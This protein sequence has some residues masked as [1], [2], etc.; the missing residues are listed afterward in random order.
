[1][2]LRI[3]KFKEAKEHKDDI[4]RGSMACPYLRKI[5]LGR[6]CIATTP[7]ERLNKNK[8]QQLCATE[9]DF[10]SCPKYIAKFR[11]ESTPFKL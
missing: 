5:F 2:T 3:S 4:V 11:E 7:Q 1:M 10:T 8:V 6:S 9:E